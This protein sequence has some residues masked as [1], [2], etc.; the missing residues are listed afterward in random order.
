MKWKA[1]GIIAGALLVV[2]LSDVSSGLL[3]KPIIHRLRPIHD[4]YF[5][6]FFRPLVSKGGLY[7]FPSSHAANHMGLAIYFYLAINRI[8]NKKWRWL[9]LWA[10]LIGYAQI[11]VGKHFP[12]DIIVGYLLGG[13]V[14]SVV[15]FS[16]L[17]TK[18]NSLFELPNSNYSG[19]SRNE[20]SF[21]NQL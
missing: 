9:F 12:S 13:I 1:F 16:L 4:P 20:L 6:H 10:G 5:S 15:F 17:K 7:S 14:A 18:A 19:K 8:W 3:L 21:N 2:I 11:Y